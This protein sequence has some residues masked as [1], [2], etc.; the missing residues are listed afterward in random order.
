MTVETATQWSEL[1]PALPS[2]NDLKREAPQH[3]ALLKNLGKNYFSSL[4]ATYLTVS[5]IELNYSAGLTGL[6]Q[7]QL[8]ALDLAKANK[9]GAVY[10]GTHDFTGATTTAATPTLG[11]S[12]AKVATTAFVAATAFSSTLPGQTGKANHWL[13]TNGSLASWEYLSLNFVP[14]SVN[15]VAEPGNIYIITVAG[16]TLTVPT[17]FNANEPF[18]YG[19]SQGLTNAFVD[20]GTNKLKGRTPGL[21][22]LTG[23]NDAAVVS[24]SDAT[25]GFMEA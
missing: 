8:D 2:I 7:G 25:N 18:G 22:T 1:D 12:S 17:T 5:S 16:I 19:M 11:D 24:F 15:T 10:T 23:Q 4:G 14:I 3:F 20:W 21:M 13:K 6:I 9:S